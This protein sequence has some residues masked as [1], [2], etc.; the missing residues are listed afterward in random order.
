MNLTEESKSEVQTSNK[1]GLR[2]FKGS[3]VAMRHSSTMKAISEEDE[4]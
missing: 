1:P 4:L 3:A 2:S